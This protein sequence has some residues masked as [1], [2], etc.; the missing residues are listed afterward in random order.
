MFLCFYCDEKYNFGHK[1]KAI[2]QILIIPNSEEGFDEELPVRESF[3]FDERIDQREVATPQISLHAM[4]GILMPQTLK[5]TGCIGKSEVQILVDRGSIHNFLQSKVVSMLQLL[6][7]FDR[8]FEV[9][10]GNGEKMTYEGM[11]SAIPIQ[12]QKRIFLMDFYVLP[13]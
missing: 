2:A 11:C 1:C 8:K 10:V 7:T 12:I 9:M 5:F 6:V 4:T 13:I 3:L